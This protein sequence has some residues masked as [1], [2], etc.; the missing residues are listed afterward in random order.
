MRNNITAGGMGSFVGVDLSAITHL[1]L[2]NRM[3]IVGCNWVG[4]TGIKLLIKAKLDK[5][6]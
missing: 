6:Q 5:L 3:V 2:C 4:S 1:S